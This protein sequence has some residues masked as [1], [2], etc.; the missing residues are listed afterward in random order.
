MPIYSACRFRSQLEPLLDIK[1]Y[2]LFSAPNNLR[3][4]PSLYHIWPYDLSV[5]TLALSFLD[6]FSFRDNTTIKRSAIY[7]APDAVRFFRSQTKETTIL[8]LYCT[9]QALESH[10]PKNCLAF[11]FRPRAPLCSS[12]HSVFQE[13]AVSDGFTYKVNFH[14]LIKLNIHITIFY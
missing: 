14:Y 13:R 10:T 9:S 2:N 6:C 12:W 11:L 3:L 7:T 1:P 5:D 4:P 8:A